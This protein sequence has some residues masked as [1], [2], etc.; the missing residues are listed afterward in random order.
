MHEVNARARDY[1][2]FTLNSIGRESLRSVAAKNALGFLDPRTGQPRNSGDH[3]CA[4]R[5]I[6]RIQTH[7]QKW[8]QVGH[9]RRRLT[10]PGGTLPPAGVRIVDRRRSLTGHTE[11]AMPNSSGSAV[12]TRHVVRCC[13]G[14][15]S[16]SRR[17]THR[18]AVRPRRRDAPGGRQR[19]PEN[20]CRYFGSPRSSSRRRPFGPFPDSFASSWRPF[21][22]PPVSHQ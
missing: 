18:G 16:N 13:V 14:R 21:T 10:A 17:S 12:R 5:G 7:Q 22:L 8:H 4:N 9:C 19:P 15:T 2:A 1:G 6:S 11:T 3:L 20:R